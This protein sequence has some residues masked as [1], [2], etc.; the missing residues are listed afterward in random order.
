MTEANLF[1]SYVERGEEDQICRAA[2][3]VREDRQSRAIL[4][5]G[6]G[7]VGK[8]WMVRHLV[9]TNSDHTETVWVKP[10]DMDDSEY[11]LLSN[12]EQLIAE[13][14][15]PGNEGRH[16]AEYLE[17]LSRL[18]QYLRPRI[19]H[20]TVISHLGRIKDVFLKC[21]RQYIS[22]TGKSVVITFDTV[23]AIRGMDLLVT[24]TQLMKQLPATLF[25]LS[26]RPLPS[27]P[28][29]RTTRRQ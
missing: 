2:A 3:Q 26:G 21:Y 18:P 27:T 11:W 9:A 25:V 4:L 7:G 22:S 29:A 13:R 12:L 5:Y 6:S 17:Y 14:L 20:E 8:T 10:I 24:L 15:D 19:G 28:V 1:P 16:F 23:E